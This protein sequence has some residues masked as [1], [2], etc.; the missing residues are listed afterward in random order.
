M[1]TN[2]YVHMKIAQV[3]HQED[4]RKAEQIRQLVR[5]GSNPKPIA[6]PLALMIAVISF[7]ASRLIQ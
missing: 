6:A 5:D 3:R 2:E 1:H 4:L 7:V